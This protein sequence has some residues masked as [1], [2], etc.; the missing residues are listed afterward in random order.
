MGAETLK[1][2]IIMG[3]PAIAPAMIRTMY[4]MYD[5]MACMHGG[6]IFSDYLIRRFRFLP[7]LEISLFRES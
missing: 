3:G 2:T 6:E 1:P 5:S 4:A 7:I